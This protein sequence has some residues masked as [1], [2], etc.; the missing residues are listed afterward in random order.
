[1][2]TNNRLF[3]ALPL[4]NL[5]LSVLFYFL[6]EY[7]TPPVWFVATS[8]LYRQSNSYFSIRATW[9]PRPRNIALRYAKYMRAAVQP[10]LKILHCRCSTTELYFS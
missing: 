7:K 2:T 9:A 10:V 3:T 4:E 8:E 1:M 5:L 6:P